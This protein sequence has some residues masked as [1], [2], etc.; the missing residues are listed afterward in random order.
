M[1]FRILKKKLIFL[2][3]LMT[4]PE[5]SL[6]LEVLK[7]EE[8]LG[9]PGLILE[10]REFMMSHDITNICTFSAAQWKSF[11]KKKIW[12]M[13][14]AELLLRMK[15]Y[16]KLSQREFKSR[17]FGVQ[18]YLR[19]MSVSEARL[20]FKIQTFMTPTVRMNFRS[21]PNYRLQG[22]LCPDCNNIDTQDHV[23]S[24]IAFAHLR[25]TNL[26]QSDKELVDYFAQVIS[27]RRKH[28]SA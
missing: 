14:R 3:H 2:H 7:V 17:A 18:D 9:L 21:D 8:K 25:E 15:D 1:K 16:K 6:A 12:Q 19:T 5:D 10:C 4:L 28:E 22:W 24:C 26:L 27:H 13:N 11:V 23:M 20:R